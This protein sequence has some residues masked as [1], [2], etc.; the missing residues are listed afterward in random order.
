MTLPN[1]QSTLLNVTLSD[2]TDY[3]FNVTYVVPLP[4]LLEIA[5][6]NQKI[7]KR[8]E[9][10]KHPPDQTYLVNL[11]NDVFECD[12]S[13]VYASHVFNHM[14]LDTECTKNGTGKL[15]IDCFIDSLNINLIKKVKTCK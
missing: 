4:V 2:V 10:K 6:R 13:N 3:L 1:H 8:T 14:I 5:Q 15:W 7:W 11:S 9:I 12:V